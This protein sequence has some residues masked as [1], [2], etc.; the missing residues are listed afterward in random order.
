MNIIWHGHS[1][2][3]ITG[4]DGTIVFDPYQANSVPGLNSLKLKANLVLCSHEHDVLYVL[5]F[6][7]VAPFDFKGTCIVTYDD[8]HVGCL[9]CK[10][11]IHFVDFENLK[12]VHMGDIGCMM[13]DVSKLK[14]CDVL[15]NPIGG[16]YTI[17][18]KEALKYIERIQPRIVIPM[19]YHSHEFGYD[20]LSTNEEFIQQ[21]SSV[22]Y[23]DDC[24]EVNKDTKTQTVVFKKPRN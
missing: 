10:I 17:D 15:M 4:K 24:L 19:H 11:T 23:V 9:R 20:V 18:T 6:V 1:C 12:V 8:H 14:N 16:Y 5:Y 3:E 22:T 13:D 21:S 2:F 7:V